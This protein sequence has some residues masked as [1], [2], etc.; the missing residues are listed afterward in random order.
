[1]DQCLRSPQRGQES[2]LHVLHKHRFALCGR[3]STALFNANFRCSS[4][5]PLNA[6]PQTSAPSDV[7]QRDIWPC[8]SN[9][10]SS[11]K[12]WWSSS[13]WLRCLTALVRLFLVQPGSTFITSLT[14]TLALNFFLERERS[15]WSAFS[16]MCLTQLS[17]EVRS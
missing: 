10:C 13:S 11:L 15:R 17:C 7:E 8:F 14:T 16:A 4:A 2:L 12:L 5:T 6:L 9:C 3:V 1:M